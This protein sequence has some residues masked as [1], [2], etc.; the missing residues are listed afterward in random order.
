LL[1]AWRF[2]K[3]RTREH[4]R[5]VHKSEKKDVCGQPTVEARARARDGSLAVGGE[6]RQSS[7]AKRAV[8]AYTGYGSWRLDWP[9]TGGR[10][11]GPSRGEAQ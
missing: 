10:G 8:T 9:Q 2:R 1:G 4:N 7:R 3:P 5:R 6:H 11:R